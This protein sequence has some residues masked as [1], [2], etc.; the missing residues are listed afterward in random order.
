VLCIAF[1]DGRGAG[2][3]RAE[4]DVTAGVVRQVVGVG[5]LWYGMDNY[6]IC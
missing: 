1:Y 3:G 2:D 5:R 4:G 6:I